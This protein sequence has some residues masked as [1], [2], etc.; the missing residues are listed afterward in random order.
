MQGHERSRESIILEE[1]F[2]KL[3]E[4]RGREFL[5][6]QAAMSRRDPRDWVKRQLAELVERSHEFETFLDDFDARNNK[7]FCFLA[8]L[9][10]SVRGF[11]TVASTLRH[12]VSRFPRYNVAFESPDAA[13][14]LAETERTSRFV[15]RAIVA[16]LRAVAHECEVLKIAS[17]AVESRGDSAI[18]GETPRK[19]LPHNIDEEDIH[20]E[21]QKICE[22]AT[23]FV[24]AFDQLAW[25]GEKQIE[26]VD[27][28][29]R[30][31]SERFDEERA[32]HYES[33]VHSIQS[34]YDTYVKGTSIEARNASLPRLR[35]HASTALHL[36]QIATH[37][38]HFYE[39]H[40]NDIRFEAA[41][42][43]IATL[44][45]KGEVLDRTVN[46]CLYFAGRVMGAG[47]RFAG[48]ALSSF[49]TVRRL[50]VELPTGTTL[51]A[52]PISLIVKVVQHYGTH[53]ELEI[54]GES[55]SAN[56]IMQMIMLVGNHASTRRFVFRGDAR[57]LGDLKLLFDNNLGESG[58][59]ALPSALAYLK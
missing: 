49:L 50:E 25:A 33:L 34:K 18:H 15:G 10:A 48:E 36:L 19:V 46:Y 32:R 26:G 47:K 21:D 28:L 8:E 12:L 43:R 51:H 31:I 1:E 29:R 16:L 59:A 42:A 13:A 3:V 37:L 14:F 6:V 54:D 7:T 45:D 23:K 52:R 24:R 9:V 58:T 44:V 53:V 5:R 27:P 40:E 11:G 2:A 4:D 35:G 55:C 41:K 39:R 56:S 30:T 57:P 17:P 38:V 20:G 22:V